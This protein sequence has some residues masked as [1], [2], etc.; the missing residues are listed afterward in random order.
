MFTV[1]VSRSSEEEIFINIDSKGNVLESIDQDGNVVVLTQE[2]LDFCKLKW[3]NGECDSA[4]D[5]G[6]F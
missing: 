3:D 5:W 4:F 1:V 6:T 2:E